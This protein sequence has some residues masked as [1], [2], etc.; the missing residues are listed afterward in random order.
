VTS[1]EI[2]ANRIPEKRKKKMGNKKRTVLKE[3]KIR[4]EKRFLTPV[5]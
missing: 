1:T 4:V 3:V 2:E 5:M